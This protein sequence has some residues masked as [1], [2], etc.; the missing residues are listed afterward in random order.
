ML[1]LLVII[2]LPLSVQA[3]VFSTLVSLLD[4]PATAE[5]FSTN[6][7]TPYDAM[8]LSAAN[9]SNPQAAIGGGDVVV[10]EWGALVST[11]TVGP[12]DVADGYTSNEISVHTVRQN[13]TLSEIAE[14]YNVSINTVYWSNDISDPSL[15]NPGD[16]LVILPITGVRHVVKKGETLSTIAKKYDGDI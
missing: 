14:M 7:K 5:A 2:C 16:T 6:T 12:D 15:I 11:G 8:V 4:E 3:G 13:E 9:H 1:P 10:D